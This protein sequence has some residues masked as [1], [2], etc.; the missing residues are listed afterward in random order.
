M[1]RTT[2]AI[3]FATLS[4]AI[5][6]T[7]AT[8]TQ[9][10]KAGFEPQAYADTTGVTSVPIGWHIFCKVHAVECHASSSSAQRATLT[11]ASWK[12]LLQID[13]LVNQNIVGISDEDHYQIRAKGIANWWTYPDDGKGNCNDYAILKKRLLIEAGWPSSTLFLTVVLDHHNEGHLVL[14]AR[15]DRGDLILD[16]LEDKVLLWYQTGYTYLKRQSS[17]DPDTWLSFSNDVRNL[18]KVAALSSAT[19]QQP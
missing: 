3:A 6:T 15:T 10:P 17:E 4:L 18:D 14:M 2:A 16:N 19:T 11:E 13:Q 12:T 9:H 7:G 5:S 1:F 8:A